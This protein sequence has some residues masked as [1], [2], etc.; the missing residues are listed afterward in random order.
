MD[1]LGVVLV[2]V[3]TPSD[4]SPLLFR[5]CSDAIVPHQRPPSRAGTLLSFLLSERAG[6]RR[7]IP[8]IYGYVREMSPVTRAYATPI[9]IARAMRT[10]ASVMASRLVRRH[11]GYACDVRGGGPYATMNINVPPARFSPDGQPSPSDRGATR[12]ASSGPR[13][14]ARVGPVDQRKIACFASRKSWVQIPAGPLQFPTCR[15]S[16]LLLGPSPT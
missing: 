16:S 6:W 8:E 1:R 3:Q 10:A 2:E 11:R 14:C 12:K 7:P 15:G 9:A 13:R 5:L 4:G